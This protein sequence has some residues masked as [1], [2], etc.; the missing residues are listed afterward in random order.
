MPAKIYKVT[1]TNEERARLAAI[2]SK[3]KRNVR[4]MKRDQ[5]LLLADENQLDG[6]WKDA[7]IAKALKVHTRTA[8]RTRE[9][10]VLEGVEATLNHT[11]PVICKS[12][13]YTRFSRVKSVWMEY[14]HSMP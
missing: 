5:I 4:G 1:S 6:S 8:E 7:A 12:Q 13:G 3:G 11:R 14:L 9:T 2:V 10:C